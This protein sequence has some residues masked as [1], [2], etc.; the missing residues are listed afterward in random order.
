M[1]RVIFKNDKI[2]VQ[3]ADNSADPHLARYHSSVMDVKN[4]NEMQDFNCKD[5]LQRACK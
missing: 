5:A 1:L 4:L 2:E 3:K